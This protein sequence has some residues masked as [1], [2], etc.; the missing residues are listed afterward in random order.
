MARI[1]KLCSTIIK[2][3]NVCCPWHT[4]KDKLSAGDEVW[5]IDPSRCNFNALWYWIFYK[6]SMI[7][8]KYIQIYIWD[9]FSKQL[10]RVMEAACANSNHN[11]IINKKWITAADGNLKPWSPGCL[12][13]FPGCS[14]G[15]IPIFYFILQAHP[16]PSNLVFCLI[17]C[18][19]FHCFL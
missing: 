9:I 6:Y 7:F 18:L 5:V 15:L 2:E 10:A 4:K 8:F 1:T 3:C 12:C 14:P 16:W 13:G 17:Q 19:F 11:N